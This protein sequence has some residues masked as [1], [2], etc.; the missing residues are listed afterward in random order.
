ML[1]GLD[2]RSDFAHHLLRQ[3]NKNRFFD[4]LHLFGAASALL[5]AD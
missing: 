2:N 5:E 3:V 4:R 1:I